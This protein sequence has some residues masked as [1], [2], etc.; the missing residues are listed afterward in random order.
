MVFCS[1]LELP[2]ISIDVNS[3]PIVF[4]FRVIHL[5]LWSIWVLVVGHCRSHFLHSRSWVWLGA[6]V[7]QARRLNP[8]EQARSSRLFFLL[9]WKG[10]PYPPIKSSMGCRWIKVNILPVM[11]FKKEIIYIYVIFVGFKSNCSTIRG[12]GSSRSLQPGSHLHATGGIDQTAIACG[13]WNQTGNTYK[14]KTAASWQDS[15]AKTKTC[16]QW[17]FFAF[18][19]SMRNTFLLFY[20]SGHCVALVQH[21]TKH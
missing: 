6:R 11:E 21:R 18:R 19:K 17:D 16:I 20:M 9:H 5:M 2:I 4:N 12:T 14:S 8:D 10:P 13:W 3:M 15:T 7:L 1:H